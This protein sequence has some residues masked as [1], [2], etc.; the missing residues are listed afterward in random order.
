MAF[1]KMHQ[2]VRWDET[3]AVREWDW[4]VKFNLDD[5]VEDFMHE[6]TNHRSWYIE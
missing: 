6:L 3:S 2:G 5:M 1:Q 4:Q